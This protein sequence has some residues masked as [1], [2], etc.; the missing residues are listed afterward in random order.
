MLCGMEETPSAVNYP[1]LTVQGVR[2]PV[3]FSNVAFYRLDRAGVD[4]RTVKDRLASG[5][6]AFSLIY[7]LLAACIGNGFTGEK[8]AE[9]VEPKVASDIVIEAMGKVQPSQ[10]T[11]LR[12]PVPAEIP[13][14]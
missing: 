3:K 14:N 13:S 6:C 10:E 12:E 9:L 7:D 1:V 2:Y 4:I 5:T 8:L 11:K